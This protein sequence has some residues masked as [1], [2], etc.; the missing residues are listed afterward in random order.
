MSVCGRTLWDNFG[1]SHGFKKWSICF[2]CLMAFIFACLSAVGYWQLVMKPSSPPPPPPQENS[3]KRCSWSP[4]YCFYR[5]LSRAALCHPCFRPVSDKET[6][7]SGR[8]LSQFRSR[9]TKWGMNY[10]SCVRSLWY[11]LTIRH[12]PNTG[13]GKKVKQSRY[14]PGL[15]QRVPGI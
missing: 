15:A 11:S 9:L 14:R 2:Q 5:Q 7:H 12:Y 8:V 6:R 10:P 1:K 13:K 3:S 4:E